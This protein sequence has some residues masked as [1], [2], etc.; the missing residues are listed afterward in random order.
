MLQAQLLKSKQ[1]P[2]KST[3]QTEIHRYREQRVVTRGEGARKG[4]GIKMDKG[5]QLYSKGLIIDFW[6]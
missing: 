2:N 3:S 5:D 4:R 6:W 1:K